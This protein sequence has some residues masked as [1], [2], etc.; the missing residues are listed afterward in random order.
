MNTHGFK[1]YK[2]RNE[3]SGF[4]L[5]WQ[6]VAYAFAISWKLTYDRI[7]GS[8]QIN[9]PRANLIT[10][11]AKLSYL[12]Q[13]VYGK[14]SRRRAYFISTLDTYLG[15]FFE[16]GLNFINLNVIFNNKNATMNDIWKAVEEFNLR[17]KY[18]ENFVQFD[19]G[20]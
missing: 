8:K 16:H 7:K 11:E 1:L 19:L 9:F 13:Y 3:Y 10:P 2:S 5:K 6:Y 17:E 4:H 12:A 18:A 14:D 15:I 20:K